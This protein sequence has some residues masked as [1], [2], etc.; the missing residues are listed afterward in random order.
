ME[1]NLK[2]GPQGHVYFPKKIRECLGEEMVLIPNYC[3]G[4][5]FPKD[6]NLKRVISSLEFIIAELK[7]HQKT[8]EPGNERKNKQR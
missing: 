8:E 6:K 7:I 1:Y 2:T 4:V 3:A 5:I